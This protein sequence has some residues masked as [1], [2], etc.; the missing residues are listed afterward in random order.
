MGFNQVPVS[1]RPEWVA[2]A[3]ATIKSGAFSR[4][5]GITWYVVGGGPFDDQL[6]ASLE[7][8]AAFRKAFDDPYFAARPAFTGNCAPLPIARVTLKRQTLTW[9]GVPNAASYEIWRGS[10]KVTVTT[11]TSFHAAKRGLY[12]VRAVNLAGFGP[13]ATA[14]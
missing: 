2:D 12:R 9:T 10:K 1:V 14:R 13:F 7:F 4:L 11:K 6:N 3:A 8:K 5:A